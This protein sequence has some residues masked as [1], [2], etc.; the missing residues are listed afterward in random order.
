MR[1]TLDLYLNPQL[2]FNFDAAKKLRTD[3]KKK[4]VRTQLEIGHSKTELS[5]NLSFIRLLGDTLP[6]GEKIPT[7]AGKP[8]KNMVKLLADINGKS[9]NKL[10]P[11]LSK[12]DEGLARLLRHKD[13]TVVKLMK[14]RQA[15]KSW[16][17]HIKRIG[18]MIRQ[19]TVSGGKLRI[20]LNY[21]GGHTGRWSGGEKIN[22]QNFGGK[23]RAGQGND[24][25][26]AKV[27]ELLMAEDLTDE[28][29]RTLLIID[30]AQI[31]ARVE[32][33]FAGCDLL[34]TGFRNNEDIYSVF[35]TRLFGQPVRKPNGN[36]S[37]AEGHILSIRRGF[38]KDAILGCGYG[39]GA[40]K[41]YERCLENPDLKPLFTSGKYD[42]SFIKG[43]V[44]TYRKTYA[45]IPALWNLVERCFAFVTKHP[46]EVVSISD[47]SGKGLFERHLRNSPPSLKSAK[48]TFWNNNG[49]VNV[50]LPSGRVL[51]YRHAT[52]NRRN[53]QIGYHHGALWGGTLVENIVQAT[54]RDLLAH[55]IV[56]YEKTG[57]NV[58]LHTHDEIVGLI[59]KEGADETYKSAYKMM[60][61]GP[62]WADGIPLSAEGELSGVYKK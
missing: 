35:A 25:L 44:D 59:S 15:T 53:G 41:F 8:G 18:N 4:M 40:T 48:L 55:W 30:S 62:K 39:M 9:T 16:P 32:A 10:I 51:Y 14:A 28:Q 56:E 52:I 6:K 58:V 20:P 47:E 37:E 36:D 11:A 24:P 13:D 12:T 38:G 34:I 21:Y 1:H 5:G 54:A 43:L 57:I 33:W 22:P 2:A 46:S 27:R 3:M 61:S 29:I 19:A 31:E 26:I 42:Y 50:Q 23:G 17:G 45:E 7:K 49:V 60:C